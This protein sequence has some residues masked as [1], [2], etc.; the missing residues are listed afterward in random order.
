[1][2]DSDRGQTRNDFFLILSPSFPLPSP[3]HVSGRQPGLFLVVPKHFP[4]P[5]SL[6]LHHTSQAGSPTHTHTHTHKS[7]ITPCVKA[8][9]VTEC[10][11]HCILHG[12]GGQSRCL[13]SDRLTLPAPVGDSTFGIGA[14]PGLQIQLLNFIRYLVGLH[15]PRFHFCFHFPLFTS[16]SL[17]YISLRLDKST[18]YPLRAQKSW[19][20]QPFFFFPVHNVYPIPPF[21]SILLPFV[22]DWMHMLFMYGC[23]GG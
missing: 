7:L 5:L 20:E 18:L 1:M 4:A 17:F 12:D 16:S 8:T 10:Q 19:I 23:M 9:I 15:L 3:L 6:S 21:L 2:T 22:M 13:T 11:C 14:G